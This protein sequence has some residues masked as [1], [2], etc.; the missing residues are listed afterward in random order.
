VPL[1]YALMRPLGHGGLAL[2]TSI[3]AIVHLVVMSA[4]LAKRVQG[5][6]ARRIIVSTLRI[7]AA[8][9]AAALAAWAVSA[10]ARH[11]ETG[12]GTLGVKAAAAAELVPSFLAGML[13][14]LLFCRL[15][16][17]EEAAVFARMLARRLRR[18]GEGASP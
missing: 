17:V 18:A 8:S 3:M 7:L 12:S 1:N 2:A 16:R 13:V 9:G 5:I 6:G 15:L 14:Y 4:V 10:W 11:L